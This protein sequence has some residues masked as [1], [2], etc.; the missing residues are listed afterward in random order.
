M[1]FALVVSKG[2]PTA[3]KHK[4]QAKDRSDLPRGGKPMTTQ[5]IIE[6]LVDAR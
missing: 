2:E 5:Q 4:N 3:R 6:K 1:V